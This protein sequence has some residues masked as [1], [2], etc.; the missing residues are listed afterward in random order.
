MGHRATVVGWGPEGEFDDD[1]GVK[2]RF[3]GDE[4]PP[5]LGWLVNRRRA[6]AEL[7]RLVRDEGLDIVEAHDWGGPSAGVRPGCPV[8]VRCHG[9]AR[10]FGHL[11]SERVRPSVVSAERLALGQARSVAAV[12]CFTADMTRTLFAVKEPIEVIPNGIDVDRF[13]AHGGEV[14]TPTVLYLGTLVRKKGVLDLCRAFAR[15]A[16]AIPEARARL[17]GA[18]SRDPVTRA[19][20]TWSL[21]RDL[22]SEEVLRRIEYAGKIPYANVQDAFREASVCVFPS[23]AEAMP[24]T[25]LEAMACGRPIVAYDIGW[26]REVVVH[27]TTGL[28]VPAGDIR[29]LAEAMIR[30]LRDDELRMRLGKEARSRALARFSASGN[31][32]QTLDWYER[33]LDGSDV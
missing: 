2:V 7:R 5:K 14:G 6:R 24:L 28:L 15:V 33:V 25:W 30:V 19:P 1:G 17:V 27:E 9:S 4:H 20:S 32:K 12:S 31:A 23:Y 8:V 21:C 3:L 13:R 10:Y 11:L 22:V 26:A 18:D 16:E 29:S